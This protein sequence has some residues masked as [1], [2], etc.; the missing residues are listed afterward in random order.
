VHVWVSR[1]QQRLDGRKL[2]AATFDSCGHLQSLWLREVLVVETGNGEMEVLVLQC[3]QFQLQELF[4]PTCGLRQP[5]VG[6][7]VSPTL[8]LAEVIEDDD[9][10][11]AEV[12]FARR[13]QPAMTGD[14]P[15]VTVH[16]D[17]RVEP[18][19]PNAGRNLCNLPVGVRPGIAG[20]TG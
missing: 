9:R 11:L 6:E 2:P 14:D 3:L 4:V 19:L 10:H 13:Q 12:Q 5:V 20:R 1:A 17:R 18:K 16:Q 8:G 15:G 7:N